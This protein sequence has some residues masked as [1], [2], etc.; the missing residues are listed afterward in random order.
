MAIKLEEGGGDKA[1]MAWPLVEELFFC[2]FPYVYRILSNK[3]MEFIFGF[4]FVMIQ[5]ILFFKY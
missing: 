2:G 5:N 4:N 1:L 3:C